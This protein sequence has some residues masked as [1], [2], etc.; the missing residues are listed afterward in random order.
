MPDFSERYGYKTSKILQVESI[1]DALKNRIWSYI[2]EYSEFEHGQNHIIYKYI[3]VNFFKL[4]ID[5]IPVC[6]NGEVY[7]I[8]FLKIAKYIYF[9]ELKWHEIFDFIEFMQRIYSSEDKSKAKSFSEAINGILEEEKSGY[10]MIGNLITPI[11]DETE[12]Y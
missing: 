3:W 5:E 10:R 1:D 7:L 4:C 9:N 11:T 8:E 2:Y 12:R 6:R